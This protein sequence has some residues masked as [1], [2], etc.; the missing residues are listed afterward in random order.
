MTTV[1][2]FPP[3][4]GTG[5]DG[6]SAYEIAVDNGFVGTEEEWLASLSAT[7]DGT[8]RSFVFKSTDLPDEIVNIEA[9]VGFGEQGCALYHLTDAKD[10]DELMLTIDGVDETTPGIFNTAFVIP[11]GF[12]QGVITI[13]SSV[14][15]ELYL[16][17]DAIKGGPWLDEGFNPVQGAARIR[18]GVTSQVN[19]TT[20]TVGDSTITQLFILGS[21]VLPVETRDYSNYDSVAT[22]TLLDFVIPASFSSVKVLP[23]VA[24]TAVNVYADNDVDMRLEVFQWDAGTRAWN[25]VGDYTWTCQADGSV[26]FGSIASTVALPLYD[27]AGVNYRQLPDNGCRVRLSATSFYGGD[28][29]TFLTAAIAIK[30][31]FS[32]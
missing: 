28:T 17:T 10:G 8:N 19:V 7:A 15:Y 23:Y 16:I 25:T 1:Y 26:N 27:I 24:P 14:G 11:P 20:E 29:P 31:S 30:T 21:Q 5:V 22:G 4:I 18:V 3:N 2:P 9:I 32:V 6:K 13:K 12:T